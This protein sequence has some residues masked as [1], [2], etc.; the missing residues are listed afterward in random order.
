[1]TEHK[2]AVVGAAGALAGYKI[3]LSIGSLVNS[4]YVGIKALKTAT[5]E[6][7]MSQAALNVVMN[8]N[9]F[10]IV[11]GLVG[12]LTTGLIAMSA[13]TADAK[14][15]SEELSESID[16]AADAIK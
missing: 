10:G 6:E 16:T 1:M 5:D 8:A 13:A 14:K 2:K 3:G 11:L 15:Y 4:L 12:A 7:T 9:P